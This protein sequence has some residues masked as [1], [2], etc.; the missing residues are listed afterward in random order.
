MAKRTM[1]GR[2]GAIAALVAAGTLAG[3]G[4]PVP[5][6]AL[7]TNPPGSVELPLS[8]VIALDDGST[9]H[10]TFETRLFAL[11]PEGVAVHAE[12]G[13]PVALLPVTGDDL[14]ALG[15]EAFVLDAGA[16]TVVRI[17]A[18]TLAVT[19]FPLTGHADLHGLAVESL[20]MP[21]RVFT[22]AVADDGTRS[23]I[24]L[25]TDT[26]A[27]TV[28]ATGLGS[29]P[30]AL[31]RAGDRVVAVPVGADG[32]TTGWTYAGTRD[33]ALVLRATFPVGPR[34]RMVAADAEGVQIA[35]DDVSV[36]HLLDPATGALTEI[37]RDAAAPGTPVVVDRGGAVRVTTAG[38]VGGVVS[39]TGRAS[40]DHPQQA[41]G[42]VIDRAGRVVALADGWLFAASDGGPG[43]ARLQMWDLAPRLDG[44]SPR[45]ISFLEVDLTFHGA[46]IGGPTR[47]RLGNTAG[48]P[49]TSTDTE[50]VVRF[51]RRWAP[52]NEYEELWLESALGE[53]P[54]GRPRLYVRQMPMGPYASSLDLADGVYADL[55]RRPASAAERRAVDDA[56]YRHGDP[57][58]V[59]SGLSRS[60]AARGPRPEVLRLYRAML[61][62]WADRAGLEH[63]VAAME[64]DGASIG[65]V[66][67]A[68]AH[69]REFT[70]GYGGTGDGAFVDKLYRSILG[71][72]PEPGGRAYWLGRLAAG[73]PRWRVA[74][75]FSEAPEHRLRTAPEV[76][77]VLLR[78]GL[79]GALPT[80]E[81]RIAGA[82]RLQAG[83]PLTV[84]ARELLASR[85][86]ADRHP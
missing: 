4:G 42:A 84:L 72:A 46:G 62:R 11:G 70:T 34:A 2:A 69:S 19:T 50:A 8:E 10:P 78:L 45:A 36:A 14:V 21:S 52:T 82:D 67:R 68:V 55:L 38:P 73:V 48:E 60:P 71:R 63:W 77:V 51:A 75:L 30:L 64:D 81:E 3:P 24:R 5:V 17:D 1:V 18:N 15:D 27:V 29:H 40:P 32:A 74:L 7:I 66:A 86:Y 83:E 49:V 13:S 31:A 44:V 37:D 53:A 80:A 26:G 12:D 22:S 61:G 16:G 33:P 79:L 47:T 28:A 23:L 59:I 25:D 76:D 9:H 65:A 56:L 6:G 85:E 43:P 20:A 41:S 57:G 58:A 35:H 39:T 54:E